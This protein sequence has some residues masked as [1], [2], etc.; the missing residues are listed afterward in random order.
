MPFFTREQ[1][2]SG[3]VRANLCR[4]NWVRFTIAVFFLFFFF[5]FLTQPYCR[6]RIC[7]YNL[8]KFQC[9][10]S[11]GGLT[12]I[13][14]LIFI[15]VIKSSF[16]GKTNRYVGLFYISHGEKTVSSYG[17]RTIISLKSDHGTYVCSQAQTGGGGSKERQLFP[18]K[19]ERAMLSL[20]ICYKLNFFSKKN[21]IVIIT[22]VE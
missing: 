1:K 18:E 8:I 4:A 17:V 14:N 16:I 22:S 7:K 5:F 12:L 15:F 21:P 6:N 13:K 20:D 10:N 9:T 2:Y 19:F 11:R 3:C